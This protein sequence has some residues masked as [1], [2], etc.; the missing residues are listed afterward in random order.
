MTTF[1]V[2]LPEALTAYLQAR[3]DSGEFSTADAYIQALIQQDKARQEHLEPLLLEGLESGEATPMTA[4][5]WETIRSN[6]R[7]NQSDQSQHG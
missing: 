7:K 4:A 3:I 1:T 6:V 2:S 5:D